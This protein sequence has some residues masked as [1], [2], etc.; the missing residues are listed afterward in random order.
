MKPLLWLLACVCSAASASEWQVSELTGKT[1]TTQYGSERSVQAGELLRQGMR[2]HVEHGA[3]VIQNGE[4]QLLLIAPAQL[5]ITNLQPLTIDYTQGQLVGTSKLTLYTPQGALNLPAS[6]WRVY[7]EVEQLYLL[8]YQD[9]VTWQHRALASGSVN[10]PM[11]VPWRLYGTAEKQRLSRMPPRIDA[12]LAQGIG[13]AGDRLQ[14]D[15]ALTEAPHY[16]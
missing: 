15:D 14:H 9:S 1:L 2:L 11:R 5:T 3:L 7:G 12:E 13:I 10:L 16:W 8:S 4:Q 6:T